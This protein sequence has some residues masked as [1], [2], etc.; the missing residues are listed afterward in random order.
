MRTQVVLS[1]QTIASLI[2]GALIAS[3]FGFETT[4]QLPMLAVGAVLSLGML[5]WGWMKFSRLNNAMKQWSVG[6]SPATGMADIDD[7]LKMGLSSS[8]TSGNKTAA[9]SDAEELAE[10]KR[11]LDKVDRRTGAVDREGRPLTCGARILGVFKGYGNSLDNGIKQTS[12]CSRELHRAIEELV[13]GSE[14]QS[15][16]MNRTTSV[17]EELSSHIIAVCDTAELAL[18]ASQSVSSKVEFSLQQFQGL[19]DEMKKV[20]KHAAVRE[21]KMQQLR[22]HTKE[23]ESIVQTIGT[24]SSRTDLLALNASIESVRAGEH[25]RGFAVVAEEVRAL[26]EQSAQAVL[27]ITRRIEMVQLE[28]NQTISG[29]SGESDHMQDVIQR[30]NESLASLEM[31]C[32]TA[33]QSAEGIGG[34]SNNSNKQLQLAQQIVDVLEQGTQTTQKNRSCAEG[35]HWTAKTLD[36]ANASL[37]KS[38]DR[39]KLPEPIDTSEAVAS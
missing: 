37:E 33:N 6:Q 7:S 2:G 24:I 25:G 34:I 17:V 35:A 21:R 19:A 14:T 13:E 1:L 10:V 26:A 16:L 15:D 8:A 31:I 39:F 12:S 22:Q 20:R 28:T 9:G 27:D 32:E 29:V 38:L 23:I 3:S 5:A 30:V 4:Y 11:I 36:E 18:Q